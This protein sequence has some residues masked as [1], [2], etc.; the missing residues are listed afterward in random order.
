M[1]GLKKLSTLRGVCVDCV[2]KALHL[3]LNAV[4]DCVYLWPQGC[5]I[6]CDIH[7][8]IHVALLGRNRTLFCSY[9]DCIIASKA[10]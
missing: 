5:I 1:L 9:F 3:S 4:I 10:L 7:I 2:T 6:K 8:Y